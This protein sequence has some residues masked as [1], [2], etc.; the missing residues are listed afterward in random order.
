MDSGW[1]VPLAGRKRWTARADVQTKICEIM[2]Y[3]NIHAA[4]SLMASSSGSAT[5][6]VEV[7]EVASEEVPASWAST[8]S[9]KP[10][11]L[12]SLIPPLGPGN[13]SFCGD[14]RAIAMWVGPP[15]A[16]PRPPAPPS[17]EPRRAAP[18]RTAP[19][20]GDHGAHVRQEL[21]VH[22]TFCSFS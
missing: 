3:G 18:R 5:L 13:F 22:T 10:S 14:P 4:S 12:S 2:M 16:P 15:P 20:R 1:A 7:S 17:P 6:C 11:S 21:N 19:G 9:S 8:A